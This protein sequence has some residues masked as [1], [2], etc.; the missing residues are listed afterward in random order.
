MYE[1]QAL[2]LEV[3]SYKNAT[4]YDLIIE[5]KDGKLSMRRK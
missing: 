3:F 2:A 5:K 4:R 1:K